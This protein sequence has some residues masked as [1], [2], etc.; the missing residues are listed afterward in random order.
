MDSVFDESILRL[1][2]ASLRSAQDAP[3]WI[4]S[5]RKYPSTSLRSPERSRRVRLLTP[6]AFAPNMK[7]TQIWLELDMNGLL[8]YSDVIISS[9][10]EPIVN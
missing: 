3:S 5:L 2:S 7:C 4:E 8:W 6:L 9:Y 10:R 1:H